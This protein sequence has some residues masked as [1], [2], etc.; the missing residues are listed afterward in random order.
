MFDGLHEFQLGL[1]AQEAASLTC[2]NDLKAVHEEQNAAVHRLSW[3]SE[4]SRLQLQTVRVKD[5]GNAP[6][7][8]PR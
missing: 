2:I 8:F 1:E 3:I 6:P 7:D 4:S 5:L